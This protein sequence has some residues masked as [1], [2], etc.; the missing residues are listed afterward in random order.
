VNHFIPLVGELANDES[1]VPQR[2]R[3]KHLL[4]ALAPHS[5]GFAACSSPLRR[6]CLNP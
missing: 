6:P 5:A 3:R 4:A 2:R 1:S